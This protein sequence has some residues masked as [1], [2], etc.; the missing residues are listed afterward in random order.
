MES[1]IDRNDKEDVEES[2]CVVGRLSGAV[3]IW[4]EVCYLAELLDVVDF[5]IDTGHDEQEDNE[6]E[7]SHETCG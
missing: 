7:G 2:E 1:S 4:S 5:C 3:D 6:S